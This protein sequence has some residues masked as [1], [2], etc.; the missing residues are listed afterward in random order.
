M[1]A[2][3]RLDRSTNRTKRRFAVALSEQT[4]DRPKRAVRGETAARLRERLTEAFALAK[5]GRE[6]FVE[7]EEGHRCVERRERKGDGAFSMRIGR[8][9]GGG[10]TAR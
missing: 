5:R 8:T 1:R 10:V 2:S 7:L 6:H 3:L 9:F 4:L